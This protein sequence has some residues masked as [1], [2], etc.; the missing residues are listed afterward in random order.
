MLDGFSFDSQQRKNIS[1]ARAGPLQRSLRKA[2][3]LPTLYQSRLAH[4]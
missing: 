4:G 2:L 1:K 3:Y